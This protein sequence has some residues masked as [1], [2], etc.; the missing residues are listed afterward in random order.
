MFQSAICFDRILTSVELKEANL[1][2][3]IVDQKKSEQMQ[4]WGGGDSGDI[5]ASTLML[6]D[7][8]P[9]KLSR[10]VGPGLIMTV[11]PLK[12][13]RKD[14]KCLNFIQPV[15]YLV[16]PGVMSIPC[17]RFDSSH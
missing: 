5:S 3:D 16:N 10:F 4:I 2:T 17:H 15:W 7:L 1:L 6:Y 14:E 12:I 13:D 9:L 11:G 8:V